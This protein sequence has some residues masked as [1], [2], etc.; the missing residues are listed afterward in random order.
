MIRR[1]GRFARP[2]VGGAIVSLLA[3][4]VVV[5]QSGSAGAV[6][7]GPGKFTVKCVATAGP[8]TLERDQEFDP[9]IDVPTE[10][11]AGATFTATL[12]GGTTNLPSTQNPDGTGLV[13]TGFQN[14]STSYQVAGGQ[15]LQGTE[16]SAGQATINGTPIS[17]PGVMQFPAADQFRPFT[18]GPIPPGTL[19]TPES[20]ISIKAGAAGSK[21]EFSSIGSNTSSQIPALGA[22]SP[23]VVTCAYNALL[24]TVNVVEP[25][26]PGAPDAV[27][28]SATT[29]AGKPVTIDVLANDKPNSDGVPPD[30]NSLAI[31]TNASHGNAVVTADHKITYTPAA[32]FSGADS[33]TYKVCITP[34]TTTTAAP[35]TTTTE[36]QV[37]SAVVDP[38]TTTTVGT[39]AEPKCDTATVNV[40]VTAVAAAAATAT[41]VAPAAELPRTGG[42]S[43]PLAAGAGVLVLIGAAALAATRSRH[44]Q[45]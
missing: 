28:D 4:A 8:I 18:A 41:P 44:T 40:T 42:S 11:F 33:L 36:Q 17:P 23:A 5:A 19:V 26:P 12:P 45:P 14:L 38:T 7:Q 16:T 9:K 1:T 31:V 20:S 2:L 21:I 25:P 34:T 6:A 10:V 37:P 35:T 30:A 15:I 32:G 43:T 27:G 22:L 29:E 39:S 13:I 3:G 24:A